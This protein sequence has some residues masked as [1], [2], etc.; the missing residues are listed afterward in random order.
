MKCLGEKIWTKRI[1]VQRS[2]FGEMLREKEFCKRVRKKETKQ[3]AKG[4]KSVNYSKK[5]K[6]SKKRFMDLA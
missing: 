3:D 2:N 1:G 6:K 4:V 5:I